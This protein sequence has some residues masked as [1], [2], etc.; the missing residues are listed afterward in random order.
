MG[1]LQKIENREYPADYLLSRIRGRRAGLISDW[2]ALIFGGAPFEYLATSLYKGF[3]T[4]RSPE[5][6]W[7]D[8]MREYRWVYLRMNREFLEIFRPFFLYCELRTIF[9]CLRHIKGGKA[10][11]AGR[12]LSSSLL[13]EEMKRTLSKSKDILAAAKEI[14]EAFLDL[15]PAFAGVAETCNREGLEGFERELTI[16]YLVTTVRSRLHPLMKDFFVRIIDSRNILALYKFLRLN[17]KAVPTFIPGG[18]IS[19]SD[20][21]QIAERKDMKE[22]CRR[23][24]IN[25]EGPGLPNVETAL[26]KNISVFLRKAGRDPLGIGSVLDYLWR[27]EREVMNLGIL[28]LGREID[29]ETVRTELVY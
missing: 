14:E 22:I 23:A 25:D 28:S 10:L 4:D 6:L 11:R 16:R 24:G 29:R 9:I 27:S 12:V 1:L 8:L 13:S 7:R 18:S 20:F 26:Y 17:P 3:V 2:T 21:A 5:G 15:S 19:E